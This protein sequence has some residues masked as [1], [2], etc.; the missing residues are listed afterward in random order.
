[1]AEI[2]Q[3]FCRIC[4]EPLSWCGVVVCDKCI[5]KNYCPDGCG[6][7]T[8]SK[9]RRCKQ[10]ERRFNMLLIKF[11]KFLLENGYIKEELR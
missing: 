6:N 4:N 3:T 2:K 8:T 10:C 9:L 11:G 5:E 7:K 1:M